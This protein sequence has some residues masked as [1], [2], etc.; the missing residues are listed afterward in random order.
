M[1]LHLSQI[2]LTLALTFIFLNPRG[3][4][5]S[6]RIHPSRRMSRTSHLA[7]QTPGR[8]GELYRPATVSAIDERRK[9]GRTRHT[10]RQDP[11]MPT[12]FT[13]EE[14]RRAV[15]PYLPADAT[16]L[17]VV[18]S[19]TRNEPVVSD[20]DYWITVPERPVKEAEKYRLLWDERLGLLSLGLKTPSALQTA[21][22]NPA[23]AIFAIPAARTLLALDDPQGILK[24][25]RTT[26]QNTTWEPLKPK[27]DAEAAQSLVGLAEEAR[28]ID[29][30]LRTSHS[31][32]ALVAA[33]GIA[34]TCPWIAAYA[35]GIFVE[36]ENSFIQTVARQ[37]PDAWISAQHQALGWADAPAS[38][39]RAHAALDL[40][41]QT[42]DQF[43]TLLSPEARL[44]ARAVVQNLNVGR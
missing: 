39:Q 40:Y 14:L 20:V 25:L 27:A 8:K 24:T 1:I 32:N 42:L 43:E 21:F 6:G 22:H 17:A 10:S 2:F 26:A 44:V 28:K 9:G 18:G 31:E 36:S 4:E 19:V 15:Q 11:S 13:P 37:M 5:S 16:G 12:T 38:T 34:L 35:L 29:K 3:M 23:D 7:R 41:V 33:T 30:G